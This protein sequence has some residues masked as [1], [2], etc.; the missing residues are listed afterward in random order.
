MSEP[1]TRRTSREEA[2][3]WYDLPLYY[4][5]IFDGGTETEA[6]FLVAMHERHGQ[7]RGKNILEP[8]CGTGRLLAEMARRG[9]RGHGIDRNP[10]ML[11]FARERMASERLPVRL[12]R[13]N[14]QDFRVRGSFDLAFCLVSTFKYL[15]SEAE[16]LSHLRCVGRVVKPGGLYVLGLH[17]TDY[18]DRTSS[19]ERWTGRRD[20]V[21]VVSNLQ[22]WPA[23]RRR[24][25]ERLR[26]RLRV[27]EVARPARVFETRW[28]FRTYGPVQIRSLLRATQEWEL[29]AVHDFTHDPQH[30]IRLGGRWLDAVLILRRGS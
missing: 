23:D 12:S 17:L 3:D 24:R 5:I 6:D 2:A 22:T 19:R 9:F 11:A 10:A 21:R 26:V 1:R 28:E 4:D 30:E 14:L 13:G 18:S 16:A 29:V 8:A 7:S 25:R 15:L 20:G 27:E